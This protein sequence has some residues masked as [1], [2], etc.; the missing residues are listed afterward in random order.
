MATYYFQFSGRDRDIVGAECRDT[1]DARNNAVRVL[2]EYL[3]K[4]PGYAGEG[5]WRVTVED[6]NRRPLLNVIVAT[7]NVRG[8]SA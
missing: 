7:A 2:G 8:E 3:S 6:E 1:D 5:H 4:H